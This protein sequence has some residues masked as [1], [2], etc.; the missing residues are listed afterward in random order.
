MRAVSPLIAAILLIAFTVTTGV[1][2]IQW[3]HNFVQ[4]QVSCIGID[5]VT[6][7]LNKQANQITFSIKNRGTQSTDMQYW[8]VKITDRTGTE[9][10]CDFNT[11]AT[12]APSG[13]CV[14]KVVDQSNNPVSKLEPN[15][16]YKAVVYLDPNTINVNNIEKIELVN[17]DCAAVLPVPRI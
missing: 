5:L 17:P 10:V 8:F 16:V 6:Y 2:V 11:A 4:R 7:N 13:G 12:S 15:T 1:L 9:Y 3:G 14:Y